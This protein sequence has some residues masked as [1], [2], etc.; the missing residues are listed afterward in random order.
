MQYFVRDPLVFVSPQYSIRDASGKVWSCPDFVALNFRE[1]IVSVVEVTTGYI[2]DRLAEKVRDCQ[3]YWLGPLKALLE[4][5]KVVDATWQYR[6]DVFV[7]RSAVEASA[8]SLLC[9]A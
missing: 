3:G 4:K 1:R 6:V 9:Q 8:T 2:A 5:A 7:R